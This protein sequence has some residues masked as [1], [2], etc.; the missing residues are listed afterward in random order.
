MRYLVVV[1]KGNE[2]FKCEDELRETFRD[3][4]SW[5]TVDVVVPTYTQRIKAR[6]A[7]KF[8]D[9]RRSL[10]GRYLFVGFETWGDMH[11]YDIMECKHV[12]EIL[13]EDGV[14]FWLTA[15]EAERIKQPITMMVD[16]TAVGDSFAVGEIARIVAGPF[17]NYKVKVLKGGYVE[18]TL[19]GRS[20]K[21]KFPHHLLKKI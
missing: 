1:S 20:I 7:K 9:V 8:A 12:H 6:N 11:W 10:F 17:T 5:N 2:E 16:T 21:L 4:V 3:L 15:I 13:G 18:T 19:F 14:P